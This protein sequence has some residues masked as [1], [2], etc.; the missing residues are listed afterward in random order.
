MVRGLAWG[1]LILCVLSWLAAGHAQGRSAAND[2]PLLKAESS[3]VFVPALV[4][5]KRGVAVRN[6]DIDQF[7]LGDNGAP[8]TVV[9]LKTAGLPISLVILMQ[10]GG[11]ARRYLSSYE[12]LPELVQQLAGSAVHE[13][14]LITFDSRIEQVWHFPQRSDGVVYALTNQRA[15]DQG[16]AIKDAVAFGVRQLQA[17]PGRFRRIVLLLS[18]DAD[19]G[20]STSSQSLLKQIGSA[21]T[22]VYSLRF[23]GPESSA[24]K[25]RH[26]RKETEANSGTMEEAIEALD[27]QTAKEAAFL[28]GGSALQFADQRSFNSA[29]LATTASIRGSYT[30]GFQPKR[31]H[32]GFHRLQV[33][34]DLPNV[35]VTARKAYWSNAGQ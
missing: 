22:V 6:L 16:A 32:P 28:T 13:I 24:K 18:E 17:E 3:F 21:S 7:H 5:D 20:S 15:G 30:L 29:F 23:P 2:P 19:R 25:A 26:K 27:S 14:T 8:Q 12:A 9:H 33:A 35:V 1:G 34:T 11:A 4:Q 31:S 10:T